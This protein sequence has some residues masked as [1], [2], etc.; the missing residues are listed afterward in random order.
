VDEFRAARGITSPLMWQYS[1]ETR[2]Y[3]QS[4]EAVWWIKQHR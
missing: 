2:T 4:F 3:G 1:S